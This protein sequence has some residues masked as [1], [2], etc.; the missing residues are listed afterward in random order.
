MCGWLVILHLRMI[1]SS[2]PQEMREGAIVWI[3]RLLLEGRN[4]YAV[5]EL[6]ASTNVYGIVYHAIVWPFARVFGNG[7]TVH[8]AVSAAA[9][10]GSCTLLYRLLRRLG[11]DFVVAATGVMLFYASSL[12]WVSPLARPDGVGVFFCIASLTWLFT[13]NLTARDFA[14][15]LGFAQ[16]ALL[17][18]VYLAFP[19]FLLALYVFLFVSPK[20]GLI[21][22]AL[23]IGAAGATLAAITLIFPAYITLSIVDNIN[24]S[25]FYDIDHMKAQTY[26]WLLYSLPLTAGVV[27][28]FI[29]EI[30]SGGIRVWPRRRPSIFV[31]ATLVNTA[32]FFALFAG[33]PGAHMTYLFHLVTPL[34][35]LAVFPALSQMRW[36]RTLVVVSL[37]IAFVT[38]AHYF[39]LTFNRFRQAEATFAQIDDVM[40][41]HQQVLGSTEVAGLLALDGRP[42]VDSGHSQYFGAAATDR[43]WPDLVPPEV[44]QTRWAAFLEELDGGIRD[45]RFDLIIRSRRPGL[46]PD[47]LVAEHYARVATYDVDFPWGAQRW[48][49]DFWE[50]RR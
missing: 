16:L 39:P 45:R 41:R 49:I 21:F 35:M 20:R 3:T 32:V 12:Y 8:R 28:W 47:K 42:V 26:D 13:D 44:L 34:L 23:A 17:T 11:T 33:H 25:T 4:P 30:A 18:K 50:P 40:Q 1:V 27:A 9:I 46:I 29:R 31:F 38:N 2:A 14:I 48:P 36:P 43:P 10:A 37:P 5:A 24:S 6:P 7:F 19:P 15:G 22:A